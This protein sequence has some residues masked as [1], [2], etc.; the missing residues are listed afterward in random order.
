MESMFKRMKWQE[1]RMVLND[2]VFR[3]EH[4]KNDDWD[5]GNECFQFYKVKELMDQYEAF[6]KGKEGFVARNILEI[7]MWD[8]G[9]LVLWSELFSPMKLVGIDLQEKNPSPYFE[10]YLNKRNLKDKVKQFW[11]VDQTDT[12]KLKLIVKEEFDSAPDLIFDDASHLYQATKTSFETLFPL[13]QPGGIYII[14]D[15]AWG[16]WPEHYEDPYFYN[17]TELTKLITEI[18]EMIGSVRDA[19]AAKLTVLP[20]FV[21]IEKGDI[22]LDEDFSLESYISRREFMNLDAP[23]PVRV[24]D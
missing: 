17:E 6:F 16:H 14:E 8:G 13:L 5:Q 20:G 15:W 24:L 21:V 11:G 12:A 9:S 3:L 18:M 23:L 1:D 19:V 2:L 22:E 7:G 10:K 4:F